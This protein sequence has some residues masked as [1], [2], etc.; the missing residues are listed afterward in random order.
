V[1]EL[2]LN[3]LHELAVDVAERAGAL[4]T[5]H[6]PRKLDV[7][8]KTTPTDVVT[9]MDHESE[10]L[11]VGLLR[12]ARPDDSVVGEEGANTSGTS[13]VRWIVDPIDGTVNYLYDL[14]GWAVSI[15][16]ETADG[17]VVGVVHVPTMGETYTALLGDGAR[18]NG[19]LVRCSDQ[20]ALDQALVG[21]GFGYDAGRRASQ[22]D[23]LRH[24]LPRV[25]DIRR[26]GA[27]AVDL[28][29]VASG[30]FDCYYERGV[31]LWD[32]A[33]GALI[34]EEAGARVAGLRGAPA[35]AEFLL[36]APPALFD[37]M[38]E[39]LVA[40]NADSG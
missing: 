10:E 32:F 31:N 19:D 5:Q 16:A 38:H 14:P 4:L 39:L 15:A 13:G 8:T 35:S 25:S 40:V 29:M 3:A 34:A 22:A 21:T 6:R 28:C 27:A 36:A 30:R 23:V 11:I 1:A 17:T 18:C 12:R 9:H 2:D 20:S 26:L 33:A 7:T 24:L 37:Q